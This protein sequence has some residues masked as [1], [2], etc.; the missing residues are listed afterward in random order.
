MAMRINGNI[1]GHLSSTKQNIQ[2]T[3][4]TGHIGTVIYGYTDAEVDEMIKGALTDTNEQL[5]EING[6][7]VSNKTEHLSET[8]AMIKSAI[9][10]KGVSVSE[11]D[12]FRDYTEKISEIPY[13]DPYYEDL[14]KLRTSNG[15]NM[16]GLFTRANGDKLDLTVLDTS[17]CTDMQYMFSYCKF[18][19]IDCSGWNISKVANVQYMFENCSSNINTTGWDTSGWTSLNHTFNYFTGSIDISNWNLDNVTDVQ[20]MFVYADLKNIKGIPTIK[21][22]KVKSYQYLFN[23][24]TCDILDLSQWDIGNVTDMQRLLYGSKIRRIDLS[25]WNTSNVTNMTYAFSFGYSCPIEELII[26]DW[27]MTKT[28]SYS[29]LFP[30][31]ASYIA[32]LK[33]IDLSRSNDLTISRITS[34]LP[35]RTL[36]T[37]GDVVIPADS[38][39]E[40]ID[41]LIAKYWR[42]VGATFTLE[43]VQI[44]SELDEL[45]P[46]CTTKIVFTS[47]SPWYFDTNN[48]EFVS[49][50]ESIATVNDKGVVEG[51]AFGSVEISARLKGTQEIVGNTVTIAITNE[52]SQPNVI[53]FRSQYEPTTSYYISVNNKRVNLQDMEYHATTKIFKHDAEETITH[54]VF[55]N[56]AITELIKLNTSNIT[57][58]NS[59][60]NGCSSP[61][62]L[63]LS[64]WDTSNVTDMNFMFC[65]CLSLTSLNLSSWDT[66][67]VSSMYWMFY[68]CLSL[69][70]LDLTGWD[71]SSVTDTKQMFFSVPSTCSIY[72]SDDLWTLTESETSF[73]GTFIRV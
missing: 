1:K 40:V 43:N 51:K 69:T 54:I 32:K 21:L 61:T 30:S 34:F 23:S 52:D 58:M 22:P 13:G 67:N 48:I 2:G 44:I 9:E 70:S 63:N 15:T 38:S 46:G 26:P 64:S 60:F 29:N 8:K 28:T 27:D 36:T 10:E 5:D 11:D 4:S 59:M 62:S 3:L 31:T 68:N 55:G 47:V 16:A 45:A 56:S 24:S 18:K 20:Y 17:K 37:Y 6:E 19:N 72:V 41:G 14:Y 66:S 35:K 49:S 7:V 71:T 73:T 65:S 53:K 50:D 33:Y 39:Q 57:S 25:N 12:T 42:P